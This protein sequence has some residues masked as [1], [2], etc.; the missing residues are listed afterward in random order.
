MK[1]FRRR[2][3]IFSYVTLSVLSYEIVFPA[4]AYALTGGPST[5]EV[6]SFEPIGTSDM[7]DIFSGDFKYNIPL[8]EVDGYPVNISYNGGIN[9]DQEASWVG[10][11]WNLNPGTVN[12]NLRGIPDDFMGDEIEKK[13]NLKDNITIGGSFTQSREIFGKDLIKVTPKTGG[14]DTA[15]TGK[16]SANLSLTLG[17]NYNNYTG[18][19]IESGAGINASLAQKGCP[20]MSAGLNISHSSTSGIDLSPNLSFDFTRK[21]NEDEVQGTL[22]LSAST[23]VNSRA[24]MRQLN[25]GWNAGL[26]GLKFNG[27]KGDY[28][29]ST[30]I[31]GKNSSIVFGTQTFT[32]SIAVP[33][34]NI[35]ASLTYKWGMAA[36]GFTNPNQ[37]VNGYFSVQ[38]VKEPVIIKK[39]YGYMHLEKASWEDMMDFNR[40]KDGMVSE[41]STNLAIPVPTYDIYTVTGHGIGGTFRLYRNDNIYTREDVNSNINTNI[42]AGVD[43]AFGDK[44]KVGVNLSFVQNKSETSNIHSG[45]HLQGRARYIS[46]GDM[47]ANPLYEPAYFRAMGEP[48]RS[49]VE[50]HSALMRYALLS[51]V[52]SYDYVAPQYTVHMGKFEPLSIKALRTLSTD[53][54]G[55]IQTE[56]Q[57]RNTVMQALTAYQANRFGLERQIRYYGYD[58]YEPTDGMLT[59]NLVVDREGDHRKAHHISEIRVY[60]TDGSRYVYGLPAYNILQ[61]EISFATGNTSSTSGNCATGMVTYSTV[62]RDIEVGKDGNKRGIDHFVQRI[63]TPAYVYAHHLTGILSPDYVDMTG[64]GISDDDLGTAIRFDYQ[65]VAANYKWRTPYG[66]NVAMYNEGRKTDYTDDRGSIIYGEKEVFALHS[67]VG[68]NHIAIFYVSSRTDAVGVA[69]IHGGQDINTLYRLDSIILYN[70]Q[71]FYENG[72]AAYKIKGAHFNYQYTLCE[73]IENSNVPDSGK[74]TLKSIWFTYG[75]SFK[76]KLSPYQFTYNG[77]SDVKYNYHTKAHDRWGT[78]LYPGQSIPC[79]DADSL[80][81]AEFPFT[82]QNKTVAD[83]YAGVWCLSEI[84]LPSGGRIE[85]DYEA[86]DYAYVQDKHAMS[87]MKI[88]G[89]GSTNNYGGRSDLLYTK[90]GADVINN[91]VFFDL[92]GTTT[93]DEL[94]HIVEGIKTL[95]FTVFADVD[96]KG[97]YEFVK[98]YAE[99]DT[100]GADYYGLVNSNNSAY[101]R[102]KTVTF[103]DKDKGGSASPISKNIWNWC[104]IN[105]TD[106]V[107]PQSSANNNSKGIKPLYELAGMFNEMLSMVQG[108]NGNLKSRGF[109]QKVNLAKSFIRMNAKGS[110]KLGGGHRVKSIRINDNWAEIGT[111]NGN[112]EDFEYGQEYSYETTEQG[113]DGITRTISSGVAGFEPAVGSDENPYTLPRYV[114]PELLMVPDIQYMDDAPIGESFMPA[115]SVGYSKV[116][117]RSLSHTGVKKT[118]TGHQVFE[119]Y[120]AKD[121]PV[122]VEQT[123]IKYSMLKPSFLETLFTPT[124]LEET[125]VT[126]SQ[127]YKFEVNDMHGKPRAE[128]TYSETSTAPIGGIKYEYLTEAGDLTVLSNRVKVVSADGTITE[129]DLATEVEV[130]SD[131]RQSYNE[132]QSANVNAN[133]DFFTIAGF[134]LLIP[135]VYPGYKKTTQKVQTVVTAKVVSRYGILKKSIAIKEGSQIVTENL[136]YDEITGSVLVTSVQ[137]EFD[138]NL[139]SVTTPA[140]WA[141]D[142]GMGPA[143]KNIG[144]RISGVTLNTDTIIFPNSLNVRDFLVPGDLVCVKIESLGLHTI[145]HVY[146][147]ENSRLNLI[148]EKTGK[149][150]FPSPALSYTLEVIRPARRNM[151]AVPIQ[152]MMVAKN[153]LTGGTL[154]IDSVIS[155]S[156]VEYSDYW[157]FYCDKNYNFTCDTIYTFPLPEISSFFNEAFN[158]LNV[159]HTGLDID[160]ACVLSKLEGYGYNLTS[161]DSLFVKSEGSYA[162]VGGTATCLSC[163]DSVYLRI[164]NVY[165]GFDFAELTS[166]REETQTACSTYYSSVLGEVP[167]HELHETFRQR[168]EE[169][170]GT[171]AVDTALEVTLNIGSPFQDNGNIVFNFSRCDQNCDLTIEMPPRYCY[172]KLEAVLNMTYYSHDKFSVDLLVELPDGTMDTLTTTGFASCLALLIIDCEVECTT[173]EESTILNPYQLGILGNWR[174]LKQNAFVDS[175]TYASQPRPATDGIFSDYT[176]FWAYS[177]GD[178]KH[179]PST[180]NKW[181][182]A[183]RVSKYSPHGNELENEDALGRYSSALFGFNYT[184]PIAVAGNSKYEQLAYESFEENS[185]FWLAANC[186]ASHF[187]FSTA[188]SMVAE[189][190][191]DYAHSGNYSLRV[192]GTETLSSENE[193]TFC[194]EPTNAMGTIQMEWENCYCVGR[195]NPDTGRYI[196]SGWLKEGTDASDTSYLGAG[197]QVKLHKTGSVVETYTLKGKG[198]II[199]G[200]Q[201][202]FG[203]FRISD[204]VEMV[205]VIL[206]AGTDDTWFDDVRI[207]P[208]NSNMKTYAYDQ[209]T[210]RLMAELDENNFATYYEYDQEGALIRVKKETVKGIQTLKEVRKSIV[211]TNP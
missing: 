59:R 158:G 105:A 210:L 14:A 97:Q 104:R 146:E 10:L 142:K 208:F 131:Y 201:R 160:K 34:S 102:L 79:G 64:D 107:Y 202:V 113:P 153:P 42:G 32:P 73:G 55:N 33:M 71:D 83:E 89:F 186:Y 178:G 78:F 48:T 161:L 112:A 193:R 24:G 35:S 151:Q 180:S 26:N 147:G 19:G 136:L 47:P 133:L 167:Y 54:T 81:T 171:C 119:F 67:I 77:E 128:Y 17:L 90:S 46:S 187:Q 114:T 163:Q 129:K 30:G 57:P 20:S 195:F 118:A 172:R 141:Y 25:F 58:Q 80:S 38:S 123:A 61:E 2:T 110:R 169:M 148:N 173:P 69:G 9:T 13:I 36:K 1:A 44:F 3:V 7:V 197:I 175:R 65:L 130:Q 209:I 40:E 45:N 87:M 41:Q 152:Q 179:M 21:A 122:I 168:L 82:P 211:K 63:K 53:P 94:D 138:D 85:I 18:V 84:R 29:G 88:V 23:S 192:D 106:L 170:A 51:P 190:T 86:D 143:Y 117:M 116:T 207:H 52:T 139:Y 166:C 188:T 164:D 203:E 4:A 200:W 27:K 184:L 121:F 125:K 162:L 185:H 108:I 120:T 37:T 154:T 93:Q 205:E 92:N 70:K 15:V 199:E 149:S 74:L 68:K 182:W 189:V 198:Q 62:N 194:A 132:V 183:N 75:N 66:E 135:S 124:R 115:A 99:A 174:M 145:C 103:K 60:S 165:V 76:G 111:A 72:S 109:G 56:R 8:M 95:Q 181:V 159:G 196:L 39:A 28:Y 91:Y 101:I 177:S 12:R 127:G 49:N 140:H 150:Y 5:P 43:V 206:V 98:G 126:A 144:M 50:T 31:G 156:A 22:R 100:L 137:N 16:L 176:P 155:A 134:P 157:P 204:S 191:D 6:Q 96:G 11:G